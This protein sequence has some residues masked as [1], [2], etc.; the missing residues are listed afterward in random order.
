MGTPIA[1][2]FRENPMKIDDLRVPLFYE[3]S[4]LG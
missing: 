3:P 2:W 1:G 4:K